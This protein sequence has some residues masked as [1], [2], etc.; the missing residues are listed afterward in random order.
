VGLEAGGF[1]ADGLPGVRMGVMAGERAGLQALSRIAPRNPT[2]QSLFLREGL[3]LEVCEFARRTPMAAEGGAAT[4]FLSAEGAVV[5]PVIRAPVQ[6]GAWSGA[7]WE[8]RVRL[9]AQ[10]RGEAILETQYPY[11]GAMLGLDF[12]SFLEAPGGVSLFLTEAKRIAG[13]ASP[14]RFSSLGLGRGGVQIWRRNLEQVGRAIQAQVTDSALR[15]ALGAA[16]QQAPIRLVGPPGFRVT[17]G[18]IQRI[19]S[20]TGRQVIVVTEP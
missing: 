8:G 3:A 14:S 7:T 2:V 9:A 13:T 1:T 12:A 6:A 19:Q 11:G 20:V 17:P 15:D 18:T 4:I 5:R 16:L 10:A